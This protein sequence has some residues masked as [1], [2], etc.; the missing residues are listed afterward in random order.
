MYYKTILVEMNNQNKEDLFREG[1]IRVASQLFQR[2]GLLKTTMEDIAKAAGKG[3]STLYYYYRSKEEIFEAVLSEEIAD[4]FNTIEG[5]IAKET[6]ATDKLRAYT[7]VAAKTMKNKTNLYRIVMGEAMNIPA[8]EG[9]KNRFDKQEVIVVKEILVSGVKS[10]EF[11]PEIAKVID[12]LSFVLV[13]SL[14]SL[15]VELLMSGDFPHWEEDC[16]KVLSSF[17][18]RGVRNN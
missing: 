13:S 15:S 18:L 12:F 2:Y 6:S 14:R 11:T 1:I 9:L 7:S 8:M 4:V 17:L 10:G 3:K 5:A 16:A